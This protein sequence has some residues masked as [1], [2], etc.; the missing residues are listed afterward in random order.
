MSALA[1]AG[2]RRILARPKLSHAQPDTLPP[3]PTSRSG[4]FRVD[5]ANREVLYR[6]LEEE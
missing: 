4:G 2:L 3:L 1:E 6:I 5:I